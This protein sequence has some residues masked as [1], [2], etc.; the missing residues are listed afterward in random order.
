MMSVYPT[1][2]L[3]TNKMP[4]INVVFIYLPKRPL[5]HTYKIFDHE[6][7]FVAETEG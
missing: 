1:I 2:R 3:M 7:T 6:N 4:T 5:V